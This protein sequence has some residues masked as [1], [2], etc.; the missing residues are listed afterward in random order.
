MQHYQEA[1]FK[2]AYKILSEK[3]DQSK[4]LEENIGCLNPYLDEKGLIRVGGCLRHS[5]L[6]EAVKH[7]I[8]LPKK[9]HITNVI[10]RWCHEKTAHSGRNMTL[11]EIRSSGYWVMQGNSVVNGLISKCATC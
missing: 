7:P 11:T 8:F 3:G 1:E 9:G 6:E 2:E 10:I 5:G 4:R